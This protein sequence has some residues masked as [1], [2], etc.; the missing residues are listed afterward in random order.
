L[1]PEES[2]DSSKD[3]QMKIIEQRIKEMKFLENLSIK[4]F[5]ICLMSKFEDAIKDLIN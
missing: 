5:K 3:I 1:S 4:N 2:V